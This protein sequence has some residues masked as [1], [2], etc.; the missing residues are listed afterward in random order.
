MRL[1][2]LPVLN[3]GPL[4][5]L[6]IQANQS[7]RREYDDSLNSIFLPLIML[8]LC[9]PAQEC[10][11]V[12]GHLGGSGGSTCDRSLLSIIGREERCAN[13]LRT[14]PDH[15]IE[16]VPWRWRRLGSKDCNSCPP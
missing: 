14:L 2:D 3:D 15:Q 10:R 9:S 5:A 7:E 12:F 11:D 16:H 4:E 6:D 8:W 13:H 1:T